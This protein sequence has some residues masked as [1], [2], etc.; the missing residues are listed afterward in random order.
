MITFYV[1]WPRK[2]FESAN[3]R[4]LKLRNCTW[5]TDWERNWAVLK[6]NSKRK[7]HAG[8]RFTKLLQFVLHRWRDW[9]E[10]E[11]GLGNMS[12]VSWMSRNHLHR[13]SDT[14]AHTLF[15]VSIWAL[16]IC[17]CLTFSISRYENNKLFWGTTEKRLNDRN[18][19]NVLSG[20]TDNCF[21][22]VLKQYT[23]GKSCFHMKN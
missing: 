8:T 16:I 14:V 15:P 22:V 21:S 9:R 3:K 4:H 1:W 11:A 12:L 20:I 17:F 5:S 2:L 10:A 19:R 18:N 6:S 13:P 23:R 7:S